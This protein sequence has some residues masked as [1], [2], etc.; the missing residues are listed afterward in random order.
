MGELLPMPSFGDLFTDL[1]GDDRTMRV[2]YHPERAVVVLSLWRGA[3]CR[4]SFRLAAEEAGRLRALLEAIEAAAVPPAG[5]AAAGGEVTPEATEV[6]QTGDI[7]G[8]ARRV[9][10]PV[11]PAPRVA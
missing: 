2:S 3:V 7:S 6:V 8:T 4:G 5:G 10:P 9:A 11:T 1:R